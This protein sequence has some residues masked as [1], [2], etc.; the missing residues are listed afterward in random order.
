[1]SLPLSVIPCDHDIHIMFAQIRYPEA[2][3]QSLSFQTAP[4]AVY[5][6]TQTIRIALRHEPQRLSD[7]EVELQACRDRSVSRQKP[8]G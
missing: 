4:L 2:Q 5:V 1:M 7:L 3:Q 6:G 8:L